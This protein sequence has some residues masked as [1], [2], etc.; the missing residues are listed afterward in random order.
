MMS[1][2]GSAVDHMARLVAFPVLVLFAGLAFLFR[3]C[4]KLVEEDVLWSRTK[5]EEKLTEEVVK[6]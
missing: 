1:V 2:P 4:G 5:R 6:V 3:L